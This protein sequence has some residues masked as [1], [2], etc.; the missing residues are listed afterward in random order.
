MDPAGRRAPVSFQSCRELLN[1]VYWAFLYCRLGL[2][3]V[4]VKSLLKTLLGASGGS[5][6]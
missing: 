1:P 3:L 5:V 4:R 2:D 6:G